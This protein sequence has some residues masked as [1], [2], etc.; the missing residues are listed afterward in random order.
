MS[1]Q[2]SQPYRR[3]PFPFS[4]PV[5]AE[6]LNALDA[7]S[8]RTTRSISALQAATKVCVKQL[9]NSGMTPEGVIVTMRAYLRHSAQEHTSTPA[10]GESNVIYE[11]LCDHLVK[12][13]IE[14]YYS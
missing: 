3:E 5:E 12:W 1:Q 4:G 11:I 8:H 6:F 9:K 14:E 10:P 2:R 7:T 13:C